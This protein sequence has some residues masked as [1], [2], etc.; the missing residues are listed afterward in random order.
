M[1]TDLETMTNINISCIDG[2]YTVDFNNSWR[3]FSTLNNTTL[4]SS[5]TFPYP[6]GNAVT[7]RT[8]DE[9]KTFLTTIRK[10]LGI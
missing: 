1:E 6:Q 9:L 4:F 10:I 2:G 8:M 3:F 7:F 5:D